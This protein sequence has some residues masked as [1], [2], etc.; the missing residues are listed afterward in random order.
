MCRTRTVSFY[1]KSSG[2]NNALWLLLFIL[3][4][5]PSGHRRLQDVLKR[6]WR[7]TTKP[8]VFKTS[9][10]KR[11][12]YNVFK[13][14]Y[15]RRLKTSNL[16]RLEG[17]RFTTSWGR[18]IFDVL[19]TS[20]LRHLEDVQFTT[21]SRHLLYVVLRTSDLRCLED[22]LFLSFWRRSINVVLKTSNL[23]RLQDVWKTTSVLQRRSDVYA[24]SKQMVFPYFVL[25][26]IFRKS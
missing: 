15:L 24:T 9:G 20:D 7:L 22:L 2:S 4:W 5:H 3:E 14:S 23:R 10:K 17:V 13:T 8:D 6:S 25:S 12:I 18:L 26:E 21:S 1:V 11:L 19:K 16:Q